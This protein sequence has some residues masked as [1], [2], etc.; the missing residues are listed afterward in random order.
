MNEIAGVDGPMV[1]NARLFEV[2][3]RLLVPA[4]LAQSRRWRRGLLRVGT[5]RFA[6]GWT[7]L[8]ESLERRGGETSNLV[9]LHPFA[10]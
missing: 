3:E 5:A 6:C 9:L 2:F 8:S 10:G 1:D 7:M 4:F